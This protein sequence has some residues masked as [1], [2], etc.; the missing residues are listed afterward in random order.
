MG[1]WEIGTFGGHFAL[2]G[3]LNN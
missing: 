2:C 3:F 1:E